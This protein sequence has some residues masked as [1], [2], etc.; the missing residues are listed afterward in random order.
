[1]SGCTPST[2]APQAVHPSA[3]QARADATATLKGCV[4]AYR[5]GERG[6]REALMEAGKLASLYV[7]QCLANGQERETAV[8]A[9][10]VELSQCAGYAV[11]ANGL[12][13]CWHAFRLL[14]LEAGIASELPWSTYYNTLCQLVTRTA[15]ATADESW[16]LLP[17]FEQPALDLFTRCQGLPRDDV[18]D[19][20]KELLQN[21]AEK[22]AAD[23]R[24][25]A[26]RADAEAKARADA[27]REARQAAEAAEREAAEAARAANEAKEQEHRAALTAAAQRANEELLARQAAEKSAVMASIIAEAARVRA[28]S[29]NKE[30]ERDAERARQR[31]AAR[32]ARAAERA[33]RKASKAKPRRQRTAVDDDKADTRSP[34]M[35]AIAR[36]GT[37]KDVAAM[38]FQLTTGSNAPDDVFRELLAMLKAQSDKVSA[39]TRHAIDCALVALNRSERTNPVNIAMRDVAAK[40]RTNGHVAACA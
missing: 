17:G 21:Y 24:E 14:S 3:V 15:K 22:Q 13:R 34:N 33:E 26:L 10:E 38:A 20:V 31:A 6:Y 29:V 30:A 12:I 16:I 4:A 37:V 32:Q 9:L 5:K 28:Q 23:A 27:E 2:I 18:A 8:K 39:T 25:Q 1:M 36:H 19:L 40:H 35:L 7:S 11:N